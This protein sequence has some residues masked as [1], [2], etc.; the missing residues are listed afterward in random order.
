MA[1]ICPQA[2]AAILRGRLPR[3]AAL[4]T[5]VVLS[6]AFNA[7]ASAQD[8]PRAAKQEAKAHFMSGQRHYNLNELT[9]ALA[10][11]KDAYR[12]YPDPVFLYNLGQCERQLGHFEEA[13]RFYRT[14]LREQPKAPNRQEVQH[15][16]EE[17]EAASKNRPPEADKPTGLPITPSPEAGS[18]PSE[19]APPAGAGPGL[20]GPGP[21][22]AT[23]AATASET[24]VDKPA[25]P[26]ENPSSSPSP[27]PSPLPVASAAVAPAAAAPEQGPAAR[28]D[29]SSS[30]QEPAPAMAP[31]FYQRW[32]FWTG[33]AVVAAGAGASIYL[34]TKG[35]SPSAPTTDLGAKK[36]F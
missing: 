34:A 18:P 5:F 7:S 4:G 28:I 13:I 32:W 12:L 19:A 33:V 10:E 25:P 1:M 8:T 6:L 20:A 11:F 22:E 2:S 14:Y 27:L 36:V 21:A 9:Q 17:M 16:I 26:A 35:T 29:L 31:A 24:P 3:L 15:K 23:A 30:T